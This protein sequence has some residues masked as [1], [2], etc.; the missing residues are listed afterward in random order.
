MKNVCVKKKEIA[1]SWVAHLEYIPVDWIIE[2]E[3]LKI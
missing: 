1:P 3:N 2:Q